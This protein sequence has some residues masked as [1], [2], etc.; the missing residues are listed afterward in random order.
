MCDEL[1]AIVIG[2]RLSNPRAQDIPR[3]MRSSVGALV[4]TLVCA[5]GKLAQ[6]GWLNH[7]VRRGWPRLHPTEELREKYVWGKIRIY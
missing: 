7:W 6:E 1:K 4:N 5:Q 3:E 2:L